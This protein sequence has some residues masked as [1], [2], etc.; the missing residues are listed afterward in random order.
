LAIGYRAW[1][2]WH[3]E[4]PYIF[5]GPTNQTIEPEDIIRV[6]IT[7]TSPTTGSIVATNQNKGWSY[8]KTLTSNSTLSLRN[9]EWVV[10][11]S[12]GLTASPDWGIVSFSYATATVSNGTTQ[13]VLL[14]GGGDRLILRTDDGLTTLS[15]V[16]ASDTKIEMKYI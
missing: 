5:G 16:T 8:N 13:V 2:E 14:P 7:T 1:Y 11:V 3:P 6:D 9:V 15:S 12:Y 10:E 4:L